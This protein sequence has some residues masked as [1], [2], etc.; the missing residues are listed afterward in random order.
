MFRT[1]G[2]AVLSTFEYIGGMALL[3]WNT[4]K[5]LLHERFPMRECLRECEA[6]GIRSLSLTNLALVFTGM[7]L[8]L[9][10][11]VGLSRFGLELY[12]GQVVGLSITRE[13]GPVLTALMIAARAGSGI[14]A[15][16]GSM[17]VTEQVM[18]ISAMG[19]NPYRLLVLPRILVAVIMTPLLTAITDVTGI[20]GGMVASMIE[21][22]V[23][24]RFYIDQILKTVEI[25]DFGSGIGKSVFFGFIIG[26]V[27]CYHGLN[28][29]GGTRG[30][31]QSTTMAVVVSSILIF[32]ADYFLT[33]LFLVL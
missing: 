10:F 11:I 27:S 19:A 31:G 13:L 25:G 21:S 18:A 22:R 30:V 33:K 28:T 16:L 20:L 8:A 12:S 6:I 26:L 32:I 24:A 5:A 3:A 17:V 14:A 23:G 2:S 1:A 4:Q 7:V 29:S 15:E 9:Q